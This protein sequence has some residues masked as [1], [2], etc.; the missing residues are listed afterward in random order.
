MSDR[1]TPLLWKI[2]GKKSWELLNSAQVFSR[3]GIWF[4]FY[5]DSDNGDV[6]L[7]LGISV[8]RK[9]GN[10]VARNT[11]KRRAK[12]VF[13][14]VLKENDLPSC[15]VLMGVSRNTPTPV[16]F[17]IIEKAVSEFSQ[18]QSNKAVK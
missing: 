8:S 4:R 6:P 16:S 15:V 2:R 5:Y 11:F 13:R 18:A 7:R 12:S 9:Y 14:H 3:H 10:A 1:T 17:S